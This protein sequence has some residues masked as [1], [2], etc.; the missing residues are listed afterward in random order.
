[1]TCPADGYDYRIYPHV[2]RYGNDKY[3]T[4]GKIPAPN[5]KRRCPQHE[6]HDLQLILC[7]A[8]WHM[9]QQEDCPTRWLVVHQG[10][11]DHPVPFPIH[12]TVQA[13][14]EVR[15][16]LENN[17]KT[18]PGSLMRGND[19]QKP[20]SQ[21]DPTF[22]N[23]DYLNH[24]KLQQRK[25]VYNKVHGHSKAFDTLDTSFEFICQ[26]H[27]EDS[28]VFKE[29]KLTSKGSPM[30]FSFQTKEMAEV[31]TDPQNQKHVDTVMSLTDTT[32]FKSIIFVTIT[33]TWNLQLQHVFSCL[34]TVH[35]GE[36]AMAFKTCH[37]DV[38]NACFEEQNITFDSLDDLF[39]KVPGTTMDF[40]HALANGWIASLNDL[41]QKNFNGKTVLQVQKESMLQ[42]CSVHY[43]N[44]VNKVSK[45]S[46]VIPPK[47]RGYIKKL[48]LTLLLNNLNFYQFQEVVNGIVTKIPN[49]RGWIK[50]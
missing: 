22:A 25:N 38:D 43:P 23:P 13:K 34:V 8:S 36:D 47:E 15:K 26:L 46:K 12:A 33:P 16:I 28:D 45:I 14:E 6:F 31:S 20:M 39:H 3:S 1:M 5:E 30:H 21:L 2:P 35:C 37:F 19:I 50:W 42:L 9:E 18:T 32:F 11:H 17:P 40:S 48:C 7:S 41:V 49:A 27:E 10:S 4:N 24:V 29:I 44:N